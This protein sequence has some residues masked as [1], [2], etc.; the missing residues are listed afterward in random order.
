[1]RSVSATTSF[2]GSFE[3]FVQTFD[4][5]NNP[6]TG[7]NP[8]WPPFNTGEQLLFNTT[9]RDT[10]SEADPSIV[11]TASIRVYGSTQTAKCDFWR[12]SISVHAG[13]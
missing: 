10:Q 7:I 12:G 8:P 1:M 6:A 11:D 4:P 9:T 2:A 13:L 3:G 5:N